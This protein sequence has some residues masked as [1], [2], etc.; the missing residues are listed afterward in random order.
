MG[1]EG[2]GVKG[3]R[4]LVG[5][6]GLPFSAARVLKSGDCRMALGTEMAAMSSRLTKLVK[7][8]DRVF[9]AQVGGLLSFS[10]ASISSIR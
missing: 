10:S 5:A 2:L 4:R 6:W 9:L 3:N 1:R 7:R 8:P